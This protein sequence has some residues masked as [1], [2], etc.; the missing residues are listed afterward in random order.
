LTPAVV[1]GKG[2]IDGVW[3]VLGIWGMGVVGDAGAAGGG[4]VALGGVRRRARGCENAMGLRILEE[5]RRELGVRRVVTVLED[6]EAV[7]LTFGLSRAV[8]LVPVESAGGRRRGG[9]W[10]C[11]MRWRTYSGG[12]CT[13]SCWRR[14]RGAM[15]WFHPLAWVACARMATERE[16]ACDDVVIA[17]GYEAAEYAAELLAVA[18]G[19]RGA[20]RMAERWAVAAAVPMARF[21]TLE[22]RLRAVLDGKRRRGRVTGMML[23]AAG[24]VV[25][26]VVVPVAMLRAAE[27]WGGEGAWGR[28]QGG[29]RRC[30]RR[31][32]LRRRH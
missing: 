7:P 5:C 27:G 28:C 32:R 22:S 6:V 15:Y 14:W 18:K 10:C 3:V 4:G 21:S 11:G 13:A 16:R 17:G 9:G 2:R 12:I 30:R 29:R 8:I 1:P 26:A 20:G 31:D 23:L 19:G 24:L 25:L